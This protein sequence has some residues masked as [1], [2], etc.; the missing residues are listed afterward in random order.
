M[1]LAACRLTQAL[2]L[3]SPVAL[4]RA[5]EPFPLARLAHLA[6]GCGV[7]AGTLSVF[8]LLSYSIIELAPQR[9]LC[10]AWRR[11]LVELANHF[12]L[13]YCYSLTGP[14]VSKPSNV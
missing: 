6:D 13:L 4:L 14:S 7:F 9:L 2:R 12:H 11:K 10:P 5:V 1:G 8:C 3:T